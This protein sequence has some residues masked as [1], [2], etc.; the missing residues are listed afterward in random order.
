MK[1]VCVF[2]CLYEGVGDLIFN[3]NFVGLNVSRKVFP[4]LSP[5]DF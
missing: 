2:V 5:F 1:T 3:K 4:A